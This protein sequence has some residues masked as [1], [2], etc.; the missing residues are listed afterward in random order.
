MEKGGKAEKPEEIRGHQ[1]LP[2]DTYPPE[3]VLYL[4]SISLPSYQQLRY[5]FLNVFYT[6]LRYIFSTTFPTIFMHNKMVFVHTGLFVT[7]LSSKS[8][9]QISKSNYVF[10]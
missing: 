4:P 5:L 6:I 3:H 10:P 2:S 7:T 1:F 8:T 9:I